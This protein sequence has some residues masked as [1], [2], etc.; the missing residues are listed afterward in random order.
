MDLDVIGLLHPGEMG[1]AVGASLVAA[2][3]TV[4]WPS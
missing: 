1:G 2:G 3:R 4:L